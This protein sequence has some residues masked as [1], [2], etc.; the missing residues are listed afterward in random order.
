M[1]ADVVPSTRKGKRFA[2]VFEDGSKT[3]FG[4]AGGNT[5]IDH[6]DKA[7]RARYRKRHLGDLRTDDP[8]RA[9]YLSFFLLWGNKTN[10]QDAIKAYNKMFFA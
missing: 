2:A 8:T 3:H 7:I 9:G 6:H 1:I 10:L 4:Q 5:Y